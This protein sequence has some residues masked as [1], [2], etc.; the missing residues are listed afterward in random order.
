[1]RISERGKNIQASPIRRLVPLADSAKKRGIKVYH[2][3]IGQPD[4]PTPEPVYEAIRNF[5]EKVLSYGPSQGLPELREE[6]AKYFNEYGIDLSMENV[7]ITV[8][9]SEAIHFAFSVIADPGDEI[10]IPEPYYTNYNGYASFAGIKIVPV[11]SKAE[12]GYRLPSVEEIESKI[13]PRTK[14]ILICSPNN[15]TGTVYND[16]ELGR[17]VYLAKKYD[18]FIIG[19]EVYKEFIYDGLKHRSIL[20][21]KGVEDRTIV[22]DSISKRFSSCGARIG[23]IITRNKEVMDSLVRF[24]QARLCPPTIEQVGAIAAYRMGISYFK[25]INEEYQRRRDAMFSALERMEG[26][27]IKKPQGAFY[28]FAKLPVDDAD[29]FAQW[30]LRDFSVDGETV[31]VAPGNGFYGTEGLGK[32]EVRLAYVLNVESINRAMAIFEKGLKEFRSR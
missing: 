9:G 11:T 8:G 10:I 31:M 19:D 26:V 15:P 14:G 7:L 18:L 2:L 23:A 24:A 21:L 6:I 30:L 20:E 13:T 32:N 5:N 22:V 4:I 12:D 16:E 29:E 28:I 1:M 3:N 27:A 25:P 17:I